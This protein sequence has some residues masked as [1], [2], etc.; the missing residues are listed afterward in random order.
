[1][2]ENYLICYICKKPIKKND[3]IAIGK[4]LVGEKLYRHKKC[5][6]HYLSTADLKQRKRWT[7]N[8]KTIIHKDKRKKSRQ[9]KKIDLKNNEN[10]Y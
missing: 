4:N 10:L 2:H 8:P 7:R 5:K 9:Q 6:P 1:M 3:Y